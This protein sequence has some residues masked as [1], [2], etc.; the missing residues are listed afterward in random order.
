MERATCNCQ[1]RER[2][3]HEGFIA[4]LPRVAGC[5]SGRCTCCCKW[6]RESKLYQFQHTLS[7]ECSKVLRFM[8]TL[9]FSL[10]HSEAPGE[11]RWKNPCVA[12]CSDKPVFELMTLANAADDLLMARPTRTR[13]LLLRGRFRLVAALDCAPNAAP[14]LSALAS[15]LLSLH[16]AHLFSCEHLSTSLHVATLTTIQ[17]RCIVLL[18]C[19]SRESLPLQT[20]S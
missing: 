4:I 8:V 6:F 20:R 11:Y 18:S 9:G 10:H 15:T 13:T 3:H 5:C 19:I 1:N 12:P 2:S 16:W 14:N 17:L 7:S